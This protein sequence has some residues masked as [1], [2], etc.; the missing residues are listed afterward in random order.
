MNGHVYKNA[1]LCI[2]FVV[3]TDQSALL[4][5]DQYEAEN[6]PKIEPTAFGL[7]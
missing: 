5:G 2:H 4:S 6:F 3:T 1:S 7:L